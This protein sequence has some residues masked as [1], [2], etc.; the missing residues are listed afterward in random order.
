MKHR[1]SLAAVLLLGAATIA[2][3]GAVRAETP[4][5]VV[6]PLT[7]RTVFTD[8]VR[9]QIRNK[10]DGQTTQVMN[11]P[12]P[13]RVVTA[14]ITVQPGARF[15]WH[16]HAGP[17]TV[18]VAQGEL[19]YVQAT[20]CVDRP[21][22]AG[23]IFVDPGQGNVHTAYNRGDGVTVVY[24]TFFDVTLDGPLTIP[25]DAPA[26]CDVTVGSHSH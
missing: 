12:D 6:E 13:S 14:R 5:I 26:D 18:S 21:Y 9:V 4:P 16:T 24:A 23:T 15:P 17:V 19:T 7:P 10:L 25:V 20:D 11:V 22:P 2:G 8:D 1:R 3:A